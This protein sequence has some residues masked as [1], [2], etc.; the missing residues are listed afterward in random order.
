VVGSKPHDSDTH[1]THCAGTLVGGDDSGQYIGLAPEAR[2]AAALGL[3]S[4]EG[5]TDAQ[6]LAGIDWA[7]Q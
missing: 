6:I 4:E 5:G 2:V 1:G 7:V 3:N